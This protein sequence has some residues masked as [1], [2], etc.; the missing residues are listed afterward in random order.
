[1]LM[2]GGGLRVMFT[3]RYVVESHVQSKGVER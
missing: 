3:L 2:L 1:M